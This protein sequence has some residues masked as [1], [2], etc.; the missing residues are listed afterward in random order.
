[1]NTRH[2]MMV[3]VVSSEVIPIPVIPVITMV[4]TVAVVT[5]NAELDDNFSGELAV[6]SIGEDTVMVEA[7]RQG[8][9]R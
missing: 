9:R 2:L 4:M 5:A 3:A 6:G 8:H 1:M 7:W